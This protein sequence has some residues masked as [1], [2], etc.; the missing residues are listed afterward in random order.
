[1]NSSRLHHSRRIYQ[2]HTHPVIRCHTNNAHRKHRYFQGG[3]HNFPAVP[4]FVPHIISYVFA[5]KH[6]GSWR[7]NPCTLWRDRRE[8]AFTDNDSAM[9]NKD[10][11]S[12]R[13][14]EDAIFQTNDELDGKPDARFDIGRS[15][16]TK[17]NDTT[18]VD[19]K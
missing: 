11:M 19:G 6:R 5:R 4:F 1:M 12:T 17:L 16:A 14:I 7:Y 2:R 9:L 15:W 8:L 13:V 10:S 18:E 3:I